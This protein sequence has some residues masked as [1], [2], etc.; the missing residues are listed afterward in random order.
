MEPNSI[1]DRVAGTLLGLSA[2]DQ[3]GGPIRMAIHL[4]ESL[5]DRESFDENDV[6]ARYLRWY[7]EEGFDTGPVA[8]R[9]FARLS[10]GEAVASAVGNVHEELERKTAGCNPAHRCPPLAMARFLKA[11]DLPE[12]AKL[13]AR[14]T[15][16]DPLAGNVSSV[17][18]VLC[19]CLILGASWQEA[20]NAAIAW[21]QELTEHTLQV[22]DRVG[23]SRGGFAPDV[24]NA[25]IY[26]L[27]HHQDFSSALCSS[28]AFA[29]CSNYC[30]V[31]V[32]TIGGARWG[33][34]CVPIEMVRDHRILPRVQSLAKAMASQW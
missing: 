29:G 34:R 9:V 26:F 6:L 15:H 3:I 33:A 2:G 23:L 13:E 27:D 30:P 5:L 14:L 10:T 19:R 8:A 1:Q 25:A 17:V 32:G 11:E 4:G 18:T 24:L 28:I 22:V 21:W 7:R 16:Y 12:M 20:L 31:L